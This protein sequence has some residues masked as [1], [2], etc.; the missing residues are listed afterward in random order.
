[1]DARSKSAASGAVE[2]ATDGKVPATLRDPGAVRFWIAVALT[3]LCA[4][5]GA[6]VLT[7]LFK[8]VEALAWGAA[9]PSALLDAARQASPRRHVGLL[10]AAG[11]VTSFGQWLLTRLTSG[12]G[13]DITAAIWFAAGRMPAWRTLGSAA[14]SI[15]IVGMGASLGREGGPNRPAPCSEICSRACRICRTNSAG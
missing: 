14:L 9:E 12:N 1:L 11:L 8:G 10:L 7:L 2:R 3:G 5:L 13:I 6:A 15:I 4:G